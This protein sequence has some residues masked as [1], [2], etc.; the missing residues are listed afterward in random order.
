MHE[1][2]K[3]G[4]RDCTESYISSILDTKCPVLWVSETSFAVLVSVRRTSFVQNYATLIYCPRDLWLY[5]HVNPPGS[6]LFEGEL[7]GGK[8][9]EASEKQNS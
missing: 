6:S 4:E 3:C 9:T 7:V 8:S 2:N 1:L 5:I